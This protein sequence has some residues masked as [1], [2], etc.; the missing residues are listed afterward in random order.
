MLKTFSENQNSF[1]VLIYKWFYAVYVW[2]ETQ[3]FR[4]L[5]RVL[6]NRWHCW[7]AIWRLCTCRASTWRE[8]SIFLAAD[9]P[10]TLQTH[11]VPFLN[12]IPI[13]SSSN[14]RTR[15]IMKILFNIYIFNS[16]DLNIDTMMLSQRITSLKYFPAKPAIESNVVDVLGLDV[17]GNVLLQH[18]GFATVY[19]D[20]GTSSFN[21]LVSIHLLQ[22]L[23]VQL[24]NISVISLVSKILMK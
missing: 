23:L 3:C 4:R 15:K 8:M 9:L 2:L 6:K 20:P 19:A 10:H 1:I 18:R 24:W 16:S 12:I 22:D 17:P 7:H 5:S 11:W 14:S 13:I 21:P